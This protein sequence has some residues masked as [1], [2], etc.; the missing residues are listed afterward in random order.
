MHPMIQ[1]TG[2]HMPVAME[3]YSKNA[4]REQSREA[5]FYRGNPCGSGTYS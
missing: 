3:E 2:G 1:H 5:R 4:V